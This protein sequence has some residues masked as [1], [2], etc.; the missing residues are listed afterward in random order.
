M[1]AETFKKPSGNPLLDYF[2]SN[3]KR[4]IH[5]WL[6]YFEIY[7]RHLMQ[8]R[9]TKLKFLEIGIQNGGSAQMW[10][11]YFGEVAKIIGVDINPWC[12]ALEAE[13]VEVW[14]GD[15]GSD[16]FWQQFLAKHQQM[17]VILDDGG[18]TMQQQITTFKALFPILNEGGLYICE[19]THSSYIPCFGGG[20]KK[21]N[22]F[23]EYV[24]DLIDDMHTW[25]FDKSE[26]IA[27]NYFA[28]HIY[29]IH[30]YDSIVVIEK[31]RKSPPVS[32]ITGLD[33]TAR[34]ENPAVSYLE[35]RAAYGVSND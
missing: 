18:H 22:T 29:A 6:G 14:I 19:D 35:M 8:F 12:K 25:Y 30:V 15:Q 26:N 1:D 16:E 3:N 17:D 10:R 9:N 32:L 5:K 33:G 13:G 4:V 31:R 34:H 7:H 27:A 2:I 11:H 28:N 23:H 20:N 24:K 21:K